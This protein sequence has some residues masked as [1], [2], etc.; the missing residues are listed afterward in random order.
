[1]ALTKQHK[2]LNILNFLSFYSLLLIPLAYIFNAP[3]INIIISL[4]VINLIVSSFINKNFL[5]FN[6]NF[7][8]VTLIFYIYIFIQSFFFDHLNILKSFSFLRFLLLPFGIYYLLNNN[9][10]KIRLIKYFYLLI[11][12]LVAADIFIQFFTGKDLLGYRADLINRI[13]GFPFEKWKTHV[14]Q[15]FSGPFGYDKKA[16]SFLLFFG[17]IG[18]FLNN[19]ILKK[20]NYPFLFFYLFILTISI[21]ITGDRGPVIILFLTAVLFIFFEKKLRL[22]SLL[23]LFI[24]LIFFCIPL[25]FSKNT[26]YRF[27]NN[28]LEYSIIS[29][30][31]SNNSNNIKNEIK[32]NERI[33]KLLFDNPWAAHYLT[34][35]EIFKDSPIFGKGI[36]S[37]R[38][39]CDK[40]PAIQSS[41]AHVRCSTHPHNLLLEILIEVGIV[42]L[43]FFTL[44]LYEFF[45]TKRTSY[46]N[47]VILYLFIATIIPIKPTGAF[48]STWFGSILW[49]LMGFYYWEINQKINKNKL[50]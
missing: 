7:F 32:I 9:L 27:I 40:Y 8:K 22:K 44:I 39:E 18:Y 16:G 14:I 31:P 12:F 3:T 2:F 1:M 30:S 48:F 33:K 23:V 37:F 46:S 47:N 38:Y 20:K 17:I 34:A 11:F 10:D 42:G 4:I 50:K 26:K 45:K 15:R 6:N 49:L 24:I 29:K 41:Y 5:T 36:R 13:E 21:T 35:I 19:N 43:L 25:L 28:I